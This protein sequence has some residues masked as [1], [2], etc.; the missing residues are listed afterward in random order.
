MGRWFA[1]RGDRA[2][3][4]LEHLGVKNIWAV[5]L[6]V[7]PKYRR[8]AWPF[9]KAWNELREMVTESLTEPGLLIVVR[10]SEAIEPYLE[11]LGFEDSEVENGFWYIEVG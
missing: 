2:V 9:L 7:N 8:R 1:V 3:V 4:W 6:A 5:H 11:R 10:G